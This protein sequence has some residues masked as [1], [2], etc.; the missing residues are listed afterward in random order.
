VFVPKQGELS[1]ERMPQAVPL[2]IPT[3]FPS[4]EMA[5]PGNKGDVGLLEKETF[6]AVMMI[7]TE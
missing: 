3:R 1:V 2:P 7:A 4:F 6:T 5:E